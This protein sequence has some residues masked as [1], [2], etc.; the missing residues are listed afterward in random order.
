MDKEKKQQKK[1]EIEKDKE[2]IKIKKREKSNRYRLKKMVEKYELLSSE[3]IQI[4]TLLIQSLIK[5]KII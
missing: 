3:K 5:L 4:K 1:L 2:L